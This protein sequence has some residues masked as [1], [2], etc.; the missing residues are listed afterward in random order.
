[1]KANIKK[2][3]EMEKGFII[4]KM[5]KDMKENF[6]MEKGKEKG[7]FFGKMEVDGKDISK[8]MK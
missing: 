3:L 1:M 6:G 2:E 8:T 7:F 4:I 5:E